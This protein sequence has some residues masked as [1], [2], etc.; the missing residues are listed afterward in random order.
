M[1]KSISVFLIALLLIMMTV[2][3]ANAKSVL[4]Y[5]DWTVTYD[6]GDETGYMIDSC[7]TADSEVVIPDLLGSNKVTGISSSA[8]LNNHTM[9][10]VQFG[11]YIRTVE[12]F[13]FLTV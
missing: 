2:S 9:Q 7:D 13:A 3:S 11:N 5:P 12:S 1:K 8:F 10:T 6:F 4:V